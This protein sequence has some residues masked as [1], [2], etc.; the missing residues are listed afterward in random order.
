MLQLL[1][2]FVYHKIGVRNPSATHSVPNGR[3]HEFIPCE[4]RVCVTKESLAVRYVLPPSGTSFHGRTAVSVTVF[5]CRRLAC[6]EQLATAPTT[7]HELRVLP[8]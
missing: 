4:L 2:Q 7:R 5:Q 3:I 6:V 1:Q 8:A